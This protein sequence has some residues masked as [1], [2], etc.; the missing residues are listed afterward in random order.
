MSKKKFITCFLSVVF[1][2]GILLTSIFVIV[3]N[4]DS[5]MHKVLEQAQKDNHANVNIDYNGNLSSKNDIP[6]ILLPVNTDDKT[7][8]SGISFDVTDNERT[9]DPSIINAT[10]EYGTKEGNACVPTLS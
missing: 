5:K 1:C 2:L 4:N 6:P 8:K 10:I 7:N 3:K 9:P